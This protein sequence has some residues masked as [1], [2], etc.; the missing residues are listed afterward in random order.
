MRKTKEQLMEE[1]D[2]D[3]TNENTRK[4]EVDRSKLL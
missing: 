3:L 4:G 1:M 2:E